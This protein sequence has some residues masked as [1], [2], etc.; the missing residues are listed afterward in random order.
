MICREKLAGAEDWFEYGF[1]VSLRA[2]WAASLVLSVTGLKHCEAFKRW[3]FV[4]GDWVMTA[5]V[6]ELMFV[7]CLLQWVRSHRN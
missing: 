1:S 7:P 3:G 4:G 2:P 6:K 5:L